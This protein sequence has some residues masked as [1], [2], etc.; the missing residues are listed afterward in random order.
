VES[1]K[2]IISQAGLRLPEYAFHYAKAN[3]RQRVSAI[4]KVNIVQDWWS[5]PQGINLPLSIW[6]IDLVSF[7][8]FTIWFI[9]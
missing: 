2:I 1:L 4:H 8:N 7:Y 9:S 5:L 3:G 6:L